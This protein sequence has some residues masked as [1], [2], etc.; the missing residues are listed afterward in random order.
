MFNGCQGTKS[1]SHVFNRNL[2]QKLEMFGMKRSI[3]DHG[4]FVYQFDDGS[5]LYM[6]TATDDLLTSAATYGHIGKLIE[7][8]KQFFTLTVQKGSVLDFLGMRIIQSELGISID[9]AEYVYEM[10]HE[11]FNSENLDYVKTASTPLR[12]DNDY[13]K[14]LYE[15]PRQTDEEF[16]L[17]CIKH[18]GSYRK[19]IGKLVY[20]AIMTRF[21]IA[22]GTQRLS[23]F[24]VRPNAPAWEGITRIMRYLAG[25][26]VRPL[27]YPRVPL[28]GKT[29]ICAQLTP[30]KRDCL[31]LSNFLNL[32]T[33]S[34]YARDPATRHTYF[35]T[36]I[37]MLG[38][39]V[40]FKVKKSTSVLPETTS[41]EVYASFRGSK[42][43][44]PIVSIVRQMG[45]IVEEPVQT[46][47]DNQATVC[48]IASERMTPRSRHL[49]I[50]IAYLHERKHRG[51]IGENQ[52]TTH[53][54]M[55]DIGTKQLVPMV[56]KRQR[57]WL[58]GH[59]FYP[60]E[61]TAH[62]KLLGL[63]FYEKS[64]VHIRDNTKMPDE[65]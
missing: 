60:P 17:S 49:D 63:Q 41:A 50:P 25:D 21:D 35:C 57:N 52:I 56:F 20:A 14:E 51:D 33:D 64:Y 40:H 32:F 13:E 38:V 42:Y 59:R 34:E 28:D 24:N 6:S 11:Y 15:A 22:Y 43:L 37:T 8:L 3:T 10:V 9:Q 36:N 27:F 16:A 2:R 48:I 23:E 55:A 18:R 12:P 29:T 54:Q 30:E 62:Y 7:F 26:I 45:I 19:H 61:G 4:L 65:D 31:T 5:Y 58:C 47:I 39:S 46:H 53:V 1:A 44:Q